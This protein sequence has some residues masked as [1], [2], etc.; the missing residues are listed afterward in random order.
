V[1]EVV[2]VVVAIAIVVEVAMVGFVVVLLFE[3]GF[4][5]KVGRSVELPVIPLFGLR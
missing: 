5:E 3:V 4:E 2:Y 1:V